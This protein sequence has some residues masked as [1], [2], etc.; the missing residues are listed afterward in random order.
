VNGL[1]WKPAFWIAYAL[2]AAAAL[3]VAWR[4]F[5]LAIPLVNLDI[6]LARH[7][8]VASAQARAERLALAPA[9]AR[10]AA[11][12]AHDQTLQNYVELEGGGKPAFAQLVAGTAYAPYWWEVR[13]F[14]PGEVTESLLRFRPDGAAYGFTRKLPETWLPADPARRALEQDV[15]R[16]LAEERAHADWDVDFALYTL[17]EQVQQK[18]TSGRVDHGFV[19]ERKGDAIGS[20]H[21]RLRLGVTG[22]ALTDVTHFAQVP[23]A[24]ERRF[25]ELRSANNTIAGAASLAA[26]L[27]YGLGGC[28]LG[29]LWLL[30]R[31]WLL[32][33]P[34]LAAGFVVGGLIGAM[35]LAA[36]P[37]AWF[38]FD[39]AQSVNTFWTRQIG[40]ALLATLGGALGY[41]LVFMAAE[42]LS[43]RAFGDHP[44]LWRVWSRAAAPTRQVLGRTVGGYLFVPIELALVAAF[45]YATNRWLG[46][47]QP[48]ESLTD[49]NI[50]GSAI[51]ALAPIALSLQAGFMEEC[52]FRAVPLS[53][54]AIIGERYGRR[55]LAIGIAVVVQALIFGGA[56][57]SYPG[58]PAYSR[59][60]ELFVPS[61]LW[62]L[63]FL[64]FGLV[65]TIVLHAVFDLALFAIPVFLV[66]APGGDLQRVLVVAAGL[67]PLGIVAVQRIR[68][69]AWGELAADLRNAA[70]QPA[71]RAVDL[72]PP[73]GERGPA[74]IAGWIATFQ[75][76]LPLLGV[77]G[78]AAWAWHTPFRTD[79]PPLPQERGQAVAAADAVLAARGIALAPEWRRLSA[80]KLALDDPGQAQWHKFVWREAGGDAYRKLVGTT[81]APPAWEVRYARFDGDVADRAEEW[82]V[83]IVGDGTARVV[84]HTL[85]EERP[86]A[87]LSRDAGLA[88]AQSALGERLR[89]DPAALALV[90]AE[91]KQ[92]PARTDW[93][94][95]F[96]EPAVDVG[97]GGQ[98]R[99]AVTLAGDE[100][101]AVGR[102]VHVPEEWQRAE[103]ERESRL[104][105]VKLVL[106]ALFSIA[107]LG[108]LVTAVLRWTRHEC[109]R[110]ALVAVAAIAFAASATGLANRW[111]L[112]AM[113]LSTAEPIVGQ[114]AIAM[115]GALLSGLLVALI[116]GLTAGVG[117]W[118]AQRQSIQPLAGRL[119]APAAGVAALLF[120]VGAGAV[121]E[122]YAPRT[123]PL[124][125]GYAGEAMAL[126][127]LAAALDG[128][129]VLLLTGAALFVL[130]WLGA[131]TAGFT[132]WRFVAV[133]LLVLGY[134]AGALLSGEGVGDAVTAGMVGGLLGAAVV[135]ALLRYDGR[136]VPA[137]LATGV[138]LQAVAD[139]A[140]KT[141]PSAW[142][143][144]ALTAAVAMTCAWVAT[145]YLERTR[146][147]RAPASAAA[148]RTL[149]Q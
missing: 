60:V 22:D 33:R 49:P 92:R 123:M 53:L 135:Y 141:G 12:F 1:A 137:Y 133:A 96:A 19:Y 122:A 61:V 10:T 97:T 55:G 113:G 7:D 109:D 87:K 114:A 66:D 132:R 73:A 116:Y 139:A 146:V 4:L 102:F 144:A 26:G 40:G 108:A 88:L 14:E 71:A 30:R 110:R 86:G 107:A 105:I 147:E 85:P 39:T 63:I 47:W 28:V 65:P 111:P 83:T 24:F 89:L 130:D 59:L 82:R 125:P 5:P 81:L 37:T 68:A 99:V 58:F 25:Q 46:W 13:L 52:V 94:F 80:P 62:A 100:I 21:L 145:R 84:R 117:A 23:E 70:W 126:P 45:Y 48:S 20:A 9:G 134:A 54:A 91:E 78:L 121:V 27:L 106:A 115:L 79:A 90:G 93:T 34:A 103:R 50:L 128:L 11:R 131:I 44:Q 3:A 95:V 72:H 36:T 15:A 2:L 143:N 64:R 16:R 57:A 98:A 56:H 149:T 51:P 76:A 8:A 43:R 120:T 35:L 138:V 129:R 101:A 75:R 41:A 6:R 140:Q 38:G 29:V 148:Q 32:W 127:A 31:H 124:W 17:L 18:R 142:V 77:A 104:T 42:S 118:A 119:R 69:A 74:A 112:V 67:V 136:A